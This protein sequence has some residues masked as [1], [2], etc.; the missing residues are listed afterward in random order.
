VSGKIKKHEVI[1]Y[2]AVTDRELEIDPQGRIWRLGSRRYNRWTKQACYYPE[3]RRRAEKSV[4]P[5]YLMVRVMWDSKRYCALAH[6]LVWHHFTGKIPD[7][8]TI[9]HKNGVK[10]DNRPE[11]LEL[12]TD[13][14]QQV[15][16]NRILG[17]GPGAN[18]WGEANPCAKLTLA[19]VEEIMEARAAGESLSQIA[20]RYPVTFQHVSAI[21]NGKARSH[22]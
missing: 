22:G 1:V 20:R 21:V 12:A 15:H 17:T 2:R 11:N 5:G 6:R 8:L 10:S 3:K 9:N 7:G 19:Q 13:A 4:P 18:Q 16:A 14:E